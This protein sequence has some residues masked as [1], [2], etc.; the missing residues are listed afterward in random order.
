MLARIKKNDTVQVISGKDKGKQGAV[1]AVNPEENKVMIK[2]VAI[3]TR[4][5]KPKKA[6][7]AGVIKK[8]EIFVHAAKVMPVCSNCKKPCRI[9]VR[10]EES[11]NK[12]RLCNQCNEIF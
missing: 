4:H 3:V 9:N 6:G 12:V 8:E 7:Q 2:G 1:I 10:I 11:D 5:V